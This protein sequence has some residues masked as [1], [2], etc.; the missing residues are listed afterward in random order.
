VAIIDLKATR[1]LKQDGVSRRLFPEKPTQLINHGANKFGYFMD[2]QLM[3]TI[4]FL[5]LSI[6]MI[7]LLQIIAV[8]GM[9]NSENL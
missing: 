7:T 2:Q 4:F 5:C 3:R 8:T 6:I 9:L 1:H